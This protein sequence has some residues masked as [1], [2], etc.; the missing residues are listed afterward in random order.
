MNNGKVRIYEL[1]KE[2]NLDNKELLAICDQLNIAVKSHS[3]TITESEAERIRSQAEKV[4]ATHQMSKKEHHGAISHKP[5]T[6]QV[7]SRNRPAASQKQELLEIRKP[8]PPKNSPGN[9]LE[10]SA[11]TNS[12]FASS[13]VNPLLPPRPFATPVS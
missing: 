2:L 12:Q 4:A 10:A 5:N 6:A 7:P 13:E 3:S 1:S 11:A 8:K 9:A